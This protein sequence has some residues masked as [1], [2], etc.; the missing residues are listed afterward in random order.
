VPLALPVLFASATAGDS[1]LAEPVAHGEI[2]ERLF[3]DAL[4]VLRRI[5]SI[6]VSDLLVNATQDHAQYK[7]GPVFSVNRTLL[8]TCRPI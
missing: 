2:R 6:E 4:L 3:F 7:G 8:D 5:E 1:A